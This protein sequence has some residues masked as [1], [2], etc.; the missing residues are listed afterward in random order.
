MR[1]CLAA[2]TGQVDQDA[3]E[4][5]VPFDRWSADVGALA[6]EFPAVRFHY[7]DDLDFASHPAVSAHQHRLYDR[8]RAVG[9]A[10]SRGR[11][12]A[13]TEDH[14]RPADD[15]V[16]QTVAAHALPYDAIGGAV[17]NGVD[18]PLNRAW[19][20]CDFGRYGRPFESQ[21]VS[22]ISDVNLSYKRPALMATRDLW[23]RS[24]QETT[25]HWAMR[26]RGIKLYLDERPV[27]FQ[28]RPRLR[29]G[30][31]IGERIS[32][33]RVFAETRVCDLNLFYRIMFSVAVIA[34]PVLLA[35][36]VLRHM[37][38]QRVTALK[39]LSTL[40]VV[41]VLLTAW[42][43]GEFIGYLIG[44]SGSTRVSTSEVPA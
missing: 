23:Q 4:I 31:V 37:L 32:W 30:Q 24:Y 41:L 1:K 17:E 14:A 38:R 26:S 7:I 21:E 22:F 20:Y 11:I 40:P 16:K 18:H 25:V 39:L 33:G 5:I 9:L 29:F 8:R 6:A 42:S 28:D 35:G 19:Y 27:V 34:L 13:M 43:V 2:L 3:T 44:P 10:L 15:W 12:V 36:R